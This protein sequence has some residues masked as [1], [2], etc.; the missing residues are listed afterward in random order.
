MER[1]EEIVEAARAARKVLVESQD[2]GS[3]ESK[4]RYSL[5]A[6]ALFFNNEKELKDSPLDG[7]FES[8]SPILEKIVGP[9]KENFKLKTNVHDYF[10]N[11]LGIDDEII[12]GVW[13]M[14][15]MANIALAE[16]KI[17]DGDKKLGWYRLG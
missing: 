13:E 12:S 10:K 2:H 7:T 1:S 5:A 11:N 9:L 17:A 14:E 4:L 3:S 6:T 15:G 16:V 8:L